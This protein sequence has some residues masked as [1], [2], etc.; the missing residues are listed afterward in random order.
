[1][2]FYLSD[3]LSLHLSLRLAATASPP[4]PSP[5]SPSDPAL[6]TS[7]RTAPA[8]PSDE[9]AATAALDRAGV[10]FARY[11]VSYDDVRDG[12]SLTQAYARQAGN[13]P[14]S[15]TIKTLVYNTGCSA[16]ILVLMPGELQV[17]TKKVRP[18]YCHQS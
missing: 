8:N 12:E 6:E 14:I 3:E 13:A 2:T 9:T 15:A 10:A 5:V 7:P 18:E 17:D 4:L 11:R 1:M 16:P